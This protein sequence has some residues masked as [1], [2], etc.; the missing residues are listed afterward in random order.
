VHPQNC[1]LDAKQRVP[2]DC[3]PDARLESAEL[4]AVHTEGTLQTLSIRV[5]QF[6]F[7]TGDVLK[8]QRTLISRHCTT[9]LTSHLRILSYTSLSVYHS[10]ASCLGKSQG[11]GQSQRKGATHH[12]GDE[13]TYSFASTNHARQQQNSV[14]TGP[15]I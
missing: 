6:K 8:L 2:K 5:A 10:R 4:A 7:R 13:R 9:R 14:R 1:L 12:I 3:S 11:T 15:A